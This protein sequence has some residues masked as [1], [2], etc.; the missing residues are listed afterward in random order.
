MHRCASECAR[1]RVYMWRPHLGERTCGGY[2]LGK[3]RICGG[4]TLRVASQALS[5]TSKHRIF[6]WPG[7]D[8]KGEADFPTSPGVLP[9]STFPALG[10]QTAMPLGSG[11]Q[12]QVFLP[13]FALVTVPS[14]SPVV[15]ILPSLFQSPA[16]NLCTPPS[17]PTPYPRYLP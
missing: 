11:D 9:V 15:G 13:A 12:V 1:V 2:T 3:V 8:Q 17:L 10:S 7:T 6:H 4:P 16:Y 14:H 5:I